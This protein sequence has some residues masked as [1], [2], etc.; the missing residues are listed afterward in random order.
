M[1]VMMPLD[2]EREARKTAELPD[3]VLS[4]NSSDRILEEG[5][6]ALEKSSFPLDCTE[7]NL[8]KV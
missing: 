8:D 7:N 2:Y 5:L 6:M 3:V 1:S 4:F